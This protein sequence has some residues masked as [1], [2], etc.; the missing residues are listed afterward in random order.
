[1]HQNP[2]LQH[3]RASHSLK[4]F[5]GFWLVFS[6]MFMAKLCGLLFFIKLLASFL[7][8]CLHIFPKSELCN[9]SFRCLNHSLFVFVTVSKFYSC[10]SFKISDFKY[11]S[12]AVI[13]KWS[14]SW[15]MLRLSAGKMSWPMGIDGIIIAFS[16]TV[17]GEQAFKFF[18]IFFSTRCNRSGIKLSHFFHCSILEF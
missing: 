3:G 10:S 2:T 16:S 14:W 12:S 9:L 18:L 1:M 11:C 13:S 7:L 15:Y 6:A 4:F 5:F 17:I 8:F